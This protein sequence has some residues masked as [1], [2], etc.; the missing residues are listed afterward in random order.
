MIRELPVGGPVRDDIF[1]YRCWADSRGHNTAA[2]NSK[3]ARDDL[4]GLCAKHY[5]EMA[6]PA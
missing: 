1:G 4:A 2:C 5:E 3:A 6:V